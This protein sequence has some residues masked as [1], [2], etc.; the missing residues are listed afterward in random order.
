MVLATK[1]ANMAG[2]V[3][4]VVMRFGPTAAFLAWLRR[5]DAKSLKGFDVEMG[6]VATGIVPPPTLLPC[7]GLCHS[8]PSIN[9]AIP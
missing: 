5:Q 3:I 4:V 9:P 1:P 8:A 7:Q 2:T 6:G